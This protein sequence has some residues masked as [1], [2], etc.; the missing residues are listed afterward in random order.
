MSFGAG[1]FY[2]RDEYDGDPLSPI[3]LNRF[4]YGNASPVSNVDP[5][6]NFTLAEVMSTLAIASDLAT[7]A[8]TSYHS[9]TIIAQAINGEIT[10]QQAVREL[11]IELSS[12]AIGYGVGFALSK[13]IKYGVPLTLRY[14]T[15]VFNNLVKLASQAGRS[16][17]KGAFAEAAFS[18]V[19]GLGKNTL[20]FISGKYTYIPDFID[21]AA[22]VMHEI[23]YYEGTIL[24]LTDQLK[25]GIA[26]A[27][28]GANGLSRYVIHVTPNTVIAPALQA[29]VRNSNGAVEI[30]RTLP[31][32][33]LES[34]FVL[35]AA[36]SSLVP[37]DDADN[38]DFASN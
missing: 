31:L 8:I 24:G 2:G 9:T 10:A 17:L 26:L 11:A 22:G 12:V 13:G 29:A 5:S 34:P 35:A 6:G 1:R 30:V 15:R 3:T 7:V 36:I 37:D 28:R 23:K 4:I 16:S 19:T 25:A 38:W 27:R 14:G 33:T 21:R 32:I 20:K 18:A